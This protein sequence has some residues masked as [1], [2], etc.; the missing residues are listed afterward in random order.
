MARLKEKY[1]NVVRP[2]LMKQFGL[3]NALAAPRLEKVVV[4]MGVGLS[5]EEKERMAAAAEDLATVTGQRPSTTKAR[6]SVSGF[7][8][9]QGMPV[10]QKVTL[11]GK[12][13]YEF[14]DRLISITIPRIRDFRGLPED[15]FDG[16]GNYNMGLAEQTVFPEVAPDKVQYSQGMNIAIVIANS[17]NEKSHE[18]L[19]AL[20]MPFR[21][22]A[23]EG[24]SES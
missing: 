19:R 11:R 10:G 12:R 14:L 3:D 24:R 1:E 20:G 17:N 6:K 2:E 22:P 21:R 8:V 9:R 23:S 5:I 7:K 13:M 15:G 4:S 16:Y 18:L